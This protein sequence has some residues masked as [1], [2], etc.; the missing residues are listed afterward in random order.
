[1][2]LIKKILGR[3]LAK[4]AV[5]LTPTQARICKT[6]GLLRAAWRLPKRLNSQIIYEQKPTISII[7][8]FR[9]FILILKVKGRLN[10]I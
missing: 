7:V 5:E 6:E 2:L 1:L 9:D 3:S 10:D 4:K 8:F